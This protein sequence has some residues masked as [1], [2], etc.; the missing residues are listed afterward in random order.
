L[1]AYNRSSLLAHHRSPKSGRPH[2]GH[3]GALTEILLVL[4]T[5]IPWGYL[6][7]ELGCGSSITRWRCLHEWML[8][9]VC[10]HIH[11]AILRN[12]RKRDQIMC[13]Q[14]CLDGASI[15]ASAG[16]EY[17]GQTQPVAAN[18]EANTIY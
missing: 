18:S 2:I 12:L 14:T 16:G 17:T 1:V 5:G 6:P 8:A 10:Q 11:E 3:R 13:G 9:G 7:H 15:P 4:K